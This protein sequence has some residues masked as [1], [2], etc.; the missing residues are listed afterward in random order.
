MSGQNP[1]T[2]EEIKVSLERFAQAIEIGLSSGAIRGNIAQFLCRL[3][4]LPRNPLLQIVIKSN[5][6]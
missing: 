2:N 1:E 6:V 4:T 3:E 5:K